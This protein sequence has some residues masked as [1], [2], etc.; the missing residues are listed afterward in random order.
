LKILWLTWKDRGHPLAG[1][2]ETIS[3]EIMDRLIRDGHKVRMVTSH[4]LDSNSYE[5]RGELEIFRTGNRYT[6][7]HC[8]KKLFKEQ[9]SGWADI[10]VDEMNTIP[11]GSGLYNKTKNTMLCY[12][13]AREVWFYQMVFPLSLFGY[14]AEPL[15]LRRLARSYST[16]LTESAST[17]ADLERYGFRTVRTFR[18]GISIAPL[19]SLTTKKSSKLILYLGAIRPMKRTLDAIKAFETARDQDNSLEMVVAGD[20]LGRYAKKIVRYAT[21]SRHSQ[22]IRILGR[23]SA[24]ER[25]SLM[26]KAK[27]ILVTSIKEGW[28]LIVTEA[29]SQGTPAIAY[30][31][32]GLRDSVQNNITGRLVKSG[33]YRAMGDQ[34][35]DLLSDQEI[36]DQLRHKA[37]DWSKE[38]TFSNSYHDF[39]KILL[40]KHI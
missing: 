38:F 1:G 33:D 11:F 34:I 14:L 7:Y 25:L 36:Y 20:T 4:Y 30:D 22:A 6:V 40:D 2:A 37:W 35:I 24:S 5:T 23:V 18:A 10:V 3:G 15:I 28:G 31:V 39:L 26:K 19:D 12:Q 8:A 13:L 29:N 27:L 9:L 17:K 16:I 32:D 21:Q